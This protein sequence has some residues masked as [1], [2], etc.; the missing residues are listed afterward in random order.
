MFHPRFFLLGGVFNDV[1]PSPVRKGKVS[2]KEM[3]VWSVAKFH[4]ATQGYVD[5]S[6]NNGT[7]KWMVYNGKPY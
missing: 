5:V 6:E 2:G 3:K 4:S 1:L 7:P